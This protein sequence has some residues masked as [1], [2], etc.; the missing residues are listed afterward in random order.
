M[1]K[2]KTI[3]MKNGRKI[4]KFNV[5]DEHGDHIECICYDETHDMFFDVVEEKKNLVVIKFPKD[6]EFQILTLL[7]QV[8]WCKNTHSFIN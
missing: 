7:S 1:E 5:V 8:I 3:V 4:M 6:Y 2:L